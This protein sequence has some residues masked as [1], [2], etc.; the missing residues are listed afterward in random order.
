M[1][2]KKIKLNNIG[3]YV[4][5]NI[6][7]FNIDNKDK[8]I[9]LIG[10]KNGAGKTTLFTA[11]KACLYGH[12]AYGYEAIGQ[13]YYQEIL[14]LI[15]SSIKTQAEAVAQVEIELLVD[16]GKYNNTYRLVREWTIK[17][18]GIKELCIVYKNNIEIQA[19]EL[20]NFFTYLDGLI[21]R[22]LFNF[23]FFDG[24]KISDYFL[25][26]D[27]TQNFKNAFL[28]LCGLDAI[29]LMVVNFE[30]IYKSKNKRS[31]A[32]NVYYEFKE[33]VEK[34]ER[35]L[36]A[37]IVKRQELLTEFD[38][39]N[40]AVSAHDLKYCQSG[41]L[42]IEEWKK[43]NRQ[44]LEQ[45]SLRESL[46]KELKEIA[47]HY[48]PFIILKKQLGKLIL[49]MDIEQDFN[50]ASILKLALSNNNVLLYLD[51][52]TKSGVDVTDVVKKIFKLINNSSINLDNFDE[53][54]CL[55]K[56]DESRLRAIIS[57]KIQ[58]DENGIQ[59]INAQLKKS[60]MQSKKLR[61]KLE[62]NNLEKMEEYSNEKEALID[63]LTKT[64]I[65]LEKIEIEIQKELEQKENLYLSFEKA[66]KDFENELK[67]NS[68]SDIASSA[69]LV[70]KNI[71]E[72]LIRRYALLLQ[73]KFIENFNAIINKDKFIDGIDVDMRLNVKPFKFIT[74]KKS[75]FLAMLKSYGEQYFINDIGV[76]NNQDIINAKSTKEDSVSL[77]VLIKT[78]FS[79]GEKQVYIMALY[80]SLLQIAKVNVPF[81]IDTP[82]ARIDSEH[83]SKIV[84]HFFKKI[85]S[86][87]IIL[88]TDEEIVGNFKK[89]MQN[90]LSG[91]LMLRS[92]SHGTSTVLN[93]QYFEVKNGI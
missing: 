44:I 15:N 29:S 66:K 73:D 33:K 81:I 56:E 53:L 2:L 90:K 9:T 61:Q 24:E 17:S 87:V 63:H 18:K 40:D 85:Q 5:E 41:G 10:G 39:S 55:S 36:Q 49:Q 78:E 47:H 31:S 6:I 77:P 89:Q 8:N 75:E 91:E 72:S 60:L 46:N 25:S 68:I 14:K 79:Q 4:G 3:P 57:N 83:R 7:T 26:N 93:D 32:S 27:S 28:T 20:A 65:A 30:R 34:F 1:K 88:S 84:E 37:D 12:K 22:D 59:K 58:F 19:D 70:Y 50:R 48:L 82:F 67:N 38:V 23:Y 92:L 21:P 76:R 69:L 42:S 54:L 64:K 86:Q 13:K 35:K 51:S 43:I 62:T 71:E 80:I 52:I 74:M 11:I 45:E 16:D